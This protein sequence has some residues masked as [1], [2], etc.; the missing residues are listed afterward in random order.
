M[1]TKQFFLPRLSGS[2]FCKEGYTRFQR[3]LKW[4]FSVG[5]KFLSL[6]TIRSYKG[7]KYFF[8]NIF[9]KYFCFF[10]CFWSLSAQSQTINTAPLDA[11]WKMT[12]PLKHGDSLTPEVW[13]DF[14]KIEA[15]QVY[16]QNQG[17]DSAYIEALRKNIEYVYMPKY[18]S[19]LSARLKDIQRDPATHW[20]TYKVYVY[21]K[22]EDVLKKYEQQLHDPAY[23]DSIYINAWQWL[24][25]RLQKKDTSVTIYLLGIENDAIAGGGTVIAT[26]WSAYNQDKLKPGILIGHEMHHVLRQGIAFKN[27]S[28]TEKGILYFLSSVLNEGTA[29]MIDKSFE[30]AHEKELPMEFQFSDF[31]L[32][33]A[34]SIL[35]QVDT[36]LL[37]MA[38]SNGQLF[39]TEK[40]YRNL[41]KWSSG[42]CP[43]YYMTDIIVRNGFKDQLLGNIQNPFYF[44]YL[45]NRAARKDPQKPPVFSQASIAYIK[46]ME[47]QYWASR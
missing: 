24:P 13:K 46:K 3:P 6:R 20:L 26:L 14:L 5:Y 12:E 23:I 1:F 38:N 2:A 22:Y 8:K 40:E 21:K 41:V 34:D 35:R 19:L 42:H 36:A 31:E 45:Y 28:A 17:F 16:I 29:D 10:V 9:M 4:V 37:H 39:K 11:Y 32:Y 25:K 15:N 30:L 43:G 47:K 44:I 18:D 33:Q 27:V 7:R